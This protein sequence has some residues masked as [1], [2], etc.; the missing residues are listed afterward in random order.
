MKVKIIIACAAISLGVAF[1]SCNKVANWQCECV[2]NGDPVVAIKLDATKKKEAKAVCKQLESENS[3]IGAKC[4][5]D[6][7]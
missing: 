3:T 4:K 7:E 6:K 1:T 2:V 5:L